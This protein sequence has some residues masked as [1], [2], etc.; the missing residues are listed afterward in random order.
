MKKNENLDLVQK[1]DKLQGGFI[2]LN[3]EKM[4]KIKGGMTGTN[5]STCTNKNTCAHTN[6]GTCTNTGSCSSSTNTGSCSNNSGR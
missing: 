5:S 2:S 1:N 4:N 3:T 6:S